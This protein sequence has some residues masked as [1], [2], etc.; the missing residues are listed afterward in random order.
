MAN[1]FHR[2]NGIENVSNV[3]QSVRKMIVNHQQHHLDVKKSL[4]SEFPSVAG[5]AP[6][7]KKLPNED[8]QLH[9]FQTAKF[10]TIWTSRRENRATLPAGVNLD[11][12]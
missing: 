7:K 5:I 8:H 1:Q 4:N 10:V 12:F 2:R 3:S 11:I 6:P 9:F